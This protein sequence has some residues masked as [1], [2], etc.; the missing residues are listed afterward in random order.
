LG[1]LGDGQEFRV[2]L[3]SPHPAQ[4]REPLS[5]NLRRSAPWA[6]R[7]CAWRMTRCAS[8]KPGRSSS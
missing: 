1:T 4:R 7:S 6:P 3:T 2:Q 5:R 8:L